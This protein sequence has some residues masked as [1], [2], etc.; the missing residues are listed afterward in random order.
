MDVSSE[1]ANEEV[2]HVTGTVYDDY[3]AELVL[4]NAQVSA[5]NVTFTIGMQDVASLNMAGIHT[6]SYP[7]Q[8][9]LDVSVDANPADWFENLY[10]FKSATIT[11][12]ITPITGE[13]DQ[14]TAVY[15]LTGSEFDRQHSEAKVITATTE[16]TEATRA[17]WQALTANVVGGSN[18][19]DNSFV[20]IKNGSWLQIGNEKLVFED[21]VD[22]LVVDPSDTNVTLVENIKNHVKVITAE[23]NKIAFGLKAGTVLAVSESKAELKND[24]EATVT[25]ITAEDLGITLSDLRKIANGELPESDDLIKTLIGYIEAPIAKLDGKN[26]VVN[27]VFTCVHD[28]KTNIEAKDATCTEDGNIAYSKCDDCGKLFDAEGNEIT[29]E[30]TVEPAK[31]HDYDYS[32]P[33]STTPATCV[34]AGETVYKCSRCDS[35]TAEPI[36]VDPNAHAWNE[37]VTTAPT[38]VDHGYTVLTCTLCGATTETNRVEPTGEHNYVNGTCTVCGAEDPNYN[39][40]GNGGNGGGTEINPN[41]NPLG[42]PLPFTDVKEENKGTGAKGDWFAPAV[43]YMYEHKDAVT[44]DPLISGTGTTTFSPNSFTTRGQLVAILWRIEGRPEAALSAFTDVSATS[45]YAKAIGW[46]SANGIVSGYDEKTFRPDR[47]VSRQE[48]AQILYKYASYKGYDVTGAADLSKYTDNGSVAD[49]AEVAMK[50]ANEEGLIS[51]RSATLLAP[52]GTTKR[53]EAAQILMKFCEG[54]KVFAE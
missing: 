51:G 36:P 48:A 33:V 41:P 8:T 23:D 9:G 46:A 35:T 39:P 6:Y 29:E 20:T 49:W 52:T 19:P 7:I 50:W 26:V 13:K 54:Y 45:Y 17:A 37:G 31:G 32:A 47:N 21:N 24:V 5:S 10:G 34:A 16:S 40:G 44:G 30:D 38:C 1:L 53:C 27:M 25:G 28:N 12:N 4:P 3:N 2:T 14:K 11:A 15:T 42:R 22:D 18:T 43:R